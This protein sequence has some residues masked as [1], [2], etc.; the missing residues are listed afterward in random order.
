M[1]GERI[2]LELLSRAGADPRGSEILCFTIVL[3]MPSR[4]GVAV[5]FIEYGIIAAGA[6][7]SDVG[8]R[9]T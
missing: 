9:E 5:R 4:S 3:Q 6:P 1:P 2:F 8:A 7:H